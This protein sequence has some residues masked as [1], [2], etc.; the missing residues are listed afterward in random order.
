[1]KKKRHKYKLGDKLKF[2][3]FDGG[4]RVGIVTKL[5]Y[6]ST[7]PNV[8]DYSK[9]TYTITIQNTNPKIKR[10]EYNY[11]NMQ[12]DRILCKFDQT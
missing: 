2:R 8:F 5:D 10:K 7:M 12:H 3:Y 11:P 4:V 9:P 1:L 6:Y